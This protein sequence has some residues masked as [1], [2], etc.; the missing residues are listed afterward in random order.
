MTVQAR[1]P[2]LLRLTDPPIILGHQCI[3]CRRVAFPPDPYGCER[4]GSPREDLEE[5]VLEAHG[6]VRAVATVHRHHQPSPATPFT[7]AVIQLTGG[8]VI[9]A[10]VA[11]AGVSVGT[12]VEGVLVQDVEDAEGNILVDLQFRVMT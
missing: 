10:I 1:H 9:K 8:P 4:C 2:Q 12:E 11:G 5:L 6:T 3:G 7:V